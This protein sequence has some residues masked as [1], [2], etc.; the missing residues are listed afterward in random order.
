MALSKITTASLADDSVTGAK[1]ENNPTIAG[2]LTVSGGF[3]PSESTSHRNMLINGNMTVH[4][5]GGTITA[6]G[7]T[8]D[9][10]QL[11]VEAMDNLAFEVTQV[12]DAP[13]TF[14]GSSGKSLKY[15]TKTVESALASDE[16]GR[17]IQKIEAQNCQYLLY[18]GSSAKSVT[19]SFWVKSS[20]TGVFA[21]M[22]YIEDGGKNIGSTYT[23]SSADT[24]EYKT[25][26]FV[27]NTSQ[28]ISNDNTIGFYVQWILMAGSNY[29]STDN[30]SWDTYA[31]GR[32]AYGH[33]QNGLATTDEST[34]QITGVQMEVGEVATPFEH[35]SYGANLARCQRYYWKWQ[36]KLSQTTIDAIGSGTD[37]I[38]QR[39]TFPVPF[40]DVPTCTKVGTWQV[41]NT[42]QPWFT[43][44]GIYST[45]FGAN[46]LGTGRGYVYPNGTDQYA[47]FEKEL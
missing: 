46:T 23:I 24:W 36:P 1:I 30:T 12:A 17:V 22:L 16:L 34:W 5:R 14:V 2:N 32:L 26:T 45:N 37:P 13:A 27:G 11:D 44:Q 3:V 38:T 39:V 21:M 18:G 41:G 25:I 15:Q 28:A 7:Y 33:A 42:G 43:S 9:R 40:R 35:E 10:W 31:A 8:L 47:T 6:E 19:L 20:L 29:T 4:Q